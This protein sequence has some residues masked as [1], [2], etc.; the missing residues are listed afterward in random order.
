MEKIQKKMLSELCEKRNR[1]S[2]AVQNVADHSWKTSIIWL[3]ELSHQS[4]DR[5][6]S[7]IQ[8]L[9]E[10]TS[11]FTAIC[12]VIVILTSDGIRHGLEN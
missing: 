12:L 2:I 7:R 4:D 9:N 11:T 10:I 6:S 3:N 1:Q 8:A 5:T